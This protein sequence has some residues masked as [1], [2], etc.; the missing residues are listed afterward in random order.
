M[1]HVPVV[2]ASQEEKSHGKDYADKNVG[3][4]YGRTFHGCVPERRGSKLIGH[5]HVSACENGKD[6][7]TAPQE[8]R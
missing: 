3:F 5:P 1:E 6:I 8:S 2:N 7:V 4:G